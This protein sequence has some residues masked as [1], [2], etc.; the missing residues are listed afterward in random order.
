M[1]FRSAALRFFEQEQQRNQQQRRGRSH[2]HSGAPAKPL[3]DCTVE[4]LGERSA[5]RKSK[6]KERQRLGPGLRWK[7]IANPT[8]GR[9]RGSGFTNTHS[10]P[11]KY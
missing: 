9:G 10:Q 7:K 1:T 8:S 4:K 2:D 6:H 5:Y 11:R 3:G